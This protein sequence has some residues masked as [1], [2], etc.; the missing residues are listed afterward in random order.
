MKTQ[1]AAF[2]ASVCA[3][4]YAGATTVSV[5]TIEP[6]GYTASSYTNP[7][8]PSPEVH[9]IGIYEA[10]TADTTG[11]HALGTA[12][13]NVNGSSDTPIDLV[14]SAYEPTQWVLQGAG[15]QSIHSVLIN[16]Y[17]AGSVSGIDL[18]KVID[19]SGP[20][21]WLGAYAYAW[22]SASGGSD[23]QALV[24]AV[25]ATYGAPISSFTGA[26]GAT[27]FTVS[28][29]AVPEPGSM[30]LMGMGLAVVAGACRAG[31]RPRTL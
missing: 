24:N 8:S 1:L 7:G 6:G 9:V 12:V 14:L 22:P 30:V 3:A 18:G 27:A 11:E 17:Y 13:V 25:E 31:R 4:T 23:T 2:L 10:Y 26:Y 5:D 16:G 19:K 20:A 21:Q 15:V 28:L 29:S